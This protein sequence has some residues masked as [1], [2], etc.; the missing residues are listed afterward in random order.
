MQLVIPAVT[1]YVRNLTDHQQRRHAAGDTC[2][3]V[4]P[5]LADQSVTASVAT[6]F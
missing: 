5:K 3:D 2:S 6:S 1:I 4:K